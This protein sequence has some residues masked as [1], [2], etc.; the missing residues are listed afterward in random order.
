MPTSGLLYPSIDAM[1]EKPIGM[2][3]FMLYPLTPKTTTN[4]ECDMATRRGLFSIIAGSAV[5]VASAAHAA[6]PIIRSAYNH[7]S[8][9]EV[10]FEGPRG[11]GK[12][13]RLFQDFVEHV[14]QGWGS[15]WRGVLFRRKYPELLDFRF[16]DFGPKNSGAVFNELTMQWEWPTGETLVVRALPDKAAYDAIHG[17]AFTWIGFDVLTEWESPIPY[18]LAGSLLRSSVKGIPLLRRA[19]TDPFGPGHGWVKSR[20]HLPEGDKRVVHLRQV[21]PIEAGYE[22]DYHRHLEQVCTE[23]ELRAWRDGSWSLING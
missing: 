13:T 10:L 17:R 12:T 23:A 6:S 11:T 2:V 9:S 15:A 14:G 18:F 3:E 22:P 21:W 8:G 1:G 7:G 20:F 5:A 16:G 19:A 4:M